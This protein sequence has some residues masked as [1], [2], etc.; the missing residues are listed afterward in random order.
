MVA[1]RRSS[2]GLFIRLAILCCLLALTV[3]FRSSGSVAQ[4]D[5]GLSDISVFRSGDSSYTD[6]V[7]LDPVTLA[8]LSSESQSE[9]DQAIMPCCVI[10]SR[11]GQTLAGKTESGDIIVQRGLG[12]EI[13]SKC[14]AG[15]AS[16]PVAFRADG[17]KL[18]VSDW[19]GNASSAAIWKVFDTATG[20][21]TRSFSYG[22]ERAGPTAIDPIAWKM[23]RIAQDKSPVV[24]VSPWA[25]RARFQNGPFI[26]KF[27]HTPPPALVAIDINSGAEVARSELSDSVWNVWEGNAEYDPTA[28]VSVYRDIIPAVAVSPDSEELALVSATDDSIT[29][30]DANTLAVKR[31]ITMHAKTGLIDHLFALFP[32]APRTASA[33]W[34]EGEG[35]FA[36]YSADGRHLYVS[37]WEAHVDENGQVYHGQGLNLVDLKDGSIEAHIL[38]GVSVYRLVA[39]PGDELFVAGSDE[40]DYS[41]TNLSRSVIVRLDGKAHKVLAERT[42]SDYVEFVIVPSPEH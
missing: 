14:H 7:K 20:T 42:F 15:V 5:S 4:D 37:G 29:L 8:D 2:R 13:V 23:F 40:S 24:A 30:I 26:L 11:D 39:T 18:L 35:R 36:S 19:N 38:D 28:R 41:E 3:E 10:F 25:N 9:F 22:S 21:L 32:L 16:F 12:G 34:Q 17:A 31:T 6:F 33:K 1:H 27:P